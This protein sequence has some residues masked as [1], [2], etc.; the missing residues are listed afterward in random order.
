M[1]T[2]R[3]IRQRGGALLAVLWVSAALS[4]IAFSVAVTVRGEMERAGTL[5]EGVRAYYLATGAIE[6][7]LLYIQWG[8]GHRNPD[9]TPRYY[10]PGMPRLLMQFP[11][12]TAEVEI[13]PESS[14]LALNEGRPEDLF[15]L[16]TVLGVEAPRAQEIT[17]AIV[18]WRSAVPGELSIFDQHYLSLTPSFR[19]R[20]SSF[21]EIEELLLVKGMTPDLFY[22]TLVR[23][24]Q[25]RLLPRAGLRDCVSVY[26]SSGAVDVNTAQP[27]VLAALGLPPEAVDAIVQRRHASPFRTMGELSPF[28][29]MAGPGASRLSLGGGTMFTFRATGRLR[30]PDGRSS[31]LMRSV[32]ALYK[33]H[34]EP[35]DTPPIE[36]LRWYDN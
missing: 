28:I 35:V 23:D 22:G 30:L 6:R 20:H 29:Q 36:L 24:A 15:R 26:G 8:P 17:M 3:T 33:F 12:G 19:A 18:D 32:S 1:E 16:L 27:A 25:G 11:T 2:N 4:A 14:K 5:S 13:I 31:D 9:G 7:L 10:E 34:E 21:E